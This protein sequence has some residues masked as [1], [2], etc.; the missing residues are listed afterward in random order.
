MKQPSKIQADD[1]RQRLQASTSFDGLVD[2]L[3]FIQA[4][5]ESDKEKHIK[6][7]QR[8]LRYYLYSAK[9]KA[10]YT[11]EIPK[12]SGGARTISAPNRNLKYILKLIN[13]ALQCLYTPMPQAHGFIPGRSIVTN[14]ANHIKKKYVYNIDLE[15][16]FPSV[17]FKRVWGVLSM[18][19]QTKL[20]KEVARVIASL[21]CHDGVLPQ[22]APTS[23]TI[24]NLICIR[25]DKQFYFLS[26]KMGFTY[27]RYAD[28]ITISSNKD[29][30]TN[31]FKSLVEEMIQKESFELNMAKERLQ[32]N[33]VKKGKKSYRQQQTVTGIVVNSRTTV[34]KSYV[35]NLQATIHNWEK[36]GYSIASMLHEHFYIYAKGY[37]RYDG[38][39]PAIE[40][41]VMGRLEYLGMVRGK[42]DPKYQLLKMKFDSLCMKEQYTDTEYQE[43][44][45]VWENE[46]VE[47]AMNKFYAKRNLVRT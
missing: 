18:L 14:A 10:Y 46:G 30:F 29:I 34:N 45:Q 41:V 35:R 8:S 7:T 1:I 23:P 9:G 16:F 27:T 44:L 25:L 19:T 38:A 15:N 33:N 43:V 42:S 5:A 36:Y 2:V 40:D 26:K 3:N 13:I 17:E 39:I 22:G 6:I 32:V 37:H 11:F 4:I 20:H 28:D 31:D 47:K 12:K 24:S 21:C